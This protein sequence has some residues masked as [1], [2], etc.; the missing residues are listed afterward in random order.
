MKDAFILDACALIALTNQEQGAD[1][2]A[3]VLKQA[4]HG[5]IRLYM[6]RVNLYEV[7]YG[8]YREY[9]KEYALNVVENVENS[10]I[11]VTEFDREIFLEAG[12]LKATYKLSLADSIAVAQTIMLRGSILT[13]DHHEFDA[14]E[15]KE[16]LIFNLI[17]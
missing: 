2:V 7:Y 9:G 3:D 6:N 1:I 12:R 8:F 14:V 5:I 15:G 4:T 11:L 10:N 16:N 17:R 13:A